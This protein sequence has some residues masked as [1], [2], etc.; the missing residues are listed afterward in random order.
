MKDLNKNGPFSEKQRISV[1][2]GLHEKSG[3]PGILNFVSDVNLKTEDAES[4][5]YKKRFMVF[6]WFNKLRFSGSK[7]RLPRFNFE[8]MADAG[9]LSADILKKLKSKLFMTSFL[10]MYY[11]AFDKLYQA[12][13]VLTQKIT[14]HYKCINKE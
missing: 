11:L 10:S 9:Y 5:E 2:Q 4:L 1:L 8:D 14:K 12:S 7:V 13:K 3:K 6:Q